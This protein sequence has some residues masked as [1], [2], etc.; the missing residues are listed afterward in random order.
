MVAWRAQ[1]PEVMLE[2]APRDRRVL[3]RTSAEIL[4]NIAYG[5]RRPLHPRHNSHTRTSVAHRARLW[6]SVTRIQMMFGS[7]YLCIVH[8]VD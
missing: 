5:M 8:E 4:Q 1:R 3:A 6:K 7:R 2:R